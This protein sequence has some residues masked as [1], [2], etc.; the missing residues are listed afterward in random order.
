MADRAWQ[1]RP[2]VGTPGTRL[3][4]LRDNSG[5]GK[6]S[7]ASALQQR[8]GRNG[9]A[10]VSQD[11]VR[12]QVLWANDTPGNPAIGLIDVMARYA[13]DTGFSV[14]VEGILH[15]DRYAEMLR[16]LVRDHRGTTRAYFWD[17]PFDETLRRHATRA[18]TSEF[19]EQDMRDWWY[20]AVRVPALAEEVIDVGLSLDATVSRIEADCGW[21]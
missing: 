3:V 19:G 18:K 21:R 7:V 15:P 1:D 16:G 20:G 2:V 5:S 11:L 10:V 8:R 17:L 13:L 12:R 6:S 9:L 14:V 4:I